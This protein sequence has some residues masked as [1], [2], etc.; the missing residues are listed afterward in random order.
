MAVVTLAEIRELLHRLDGVS[1]DDIESETVECKSWVPHPQALDSQV[2][3]LREAVVAL[4]NQ[5]GGVVILGVADRKRT[6]KDAV[7]GVGGLDPDS[8][9]RKIYDGTEPHILV[10]IEELVEPEG[11]L[12]VVHVP[13]GIPPHTT[14]E[15]VAKIRV[16]KESKP[17]TGSQLSQILF[18]GGQKDITAQPL[19]ESSITDLDTEEIKR[20]RRIIETEGSN[21]DLA[22]VNNDAEFLSNL[23][24]LRDGQLTLAAVLLLG[25]AAALARW[26]PQHEVIFIRFK[27]STRYDVR[28]DLKG[29]LFA[30]LEVL[31]KTLQERTRL[32]L[33]GAAGLGE[34]A[35]PDL[36]WIAA[37]E[38]L[39]NALAHRDYFL[40]QSIQVHL[41]DDRLEISSPGG[42]V[43]GVS[44]QNILRHPPV[45]RNPLL[46]DALQK[47][48]L[49]NRVGMG[50]DRIYEELLKFGKR[51]PF[52]HADESTVQLVLPTVTNLGFAQLVAE[53]F[54]AG[55]RFELDDMICLSALSVRGRLDRWSA[56]KELQLPE[57]E[58]AEKL[59]SLR[60]RGYLLPQGRGR[61]T[62]Y[63]LT[64]P[65][66][67][68]LRGEDAA[69][70]DLALDD[71]AIRLRIQ[72]VLGERGKLTNAEARR[73][74]GYNRMEV[75]GLMHKIISDGHAKL[76]G[77]GRG[78]HYVSEKKRVH[79]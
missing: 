17:L 56:A 26:S 53:E 57:E 50:V 59:A 65:L 44:P 3:E 19:P 10:E 45:R 35:V 69:N 32:T 1:A 43:G 77:K 12:L 14:S 62:R 52:Y 67:D 21:P 34:L 41:Y 46:A 55:R 78:A 24:I 70:P 36:T 42:F 39:L 51:M 76:V 74:S 2:R 49:I 64:R 79:K 28:R 58:A 16:G 23:G 33:V 60:V 13:R 27:T 66:S 25:K 73:I 71:E 22:R 54:R 63:R 5:R 11:R 8:L 48:G 30:V 4:A 75:I 72:A 9:R 47:A 40:N 31:E 38:A 18:A 6:R 68:R 37:R 20:L 61:G 29:P 15:G 7:Q